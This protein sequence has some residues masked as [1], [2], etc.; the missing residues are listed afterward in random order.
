[1]SRVKA[2]FTLDEQ[3]VNELTA[4]SQG[5]SKKKSHIIETALSIYFDMMDVKLAEQ[6]SDAVD[7][8]DEETI[9][10]EDVWKEL[11]ID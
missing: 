5:L 3:V 4:F 6:I 8:G 9:P 10:A 11:G 7:A 2:T 1:M